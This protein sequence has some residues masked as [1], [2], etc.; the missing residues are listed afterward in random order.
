MNLKFL[1]THLIEFLLLFSQAMSL[2]SSKMHFFYCKKLQ[3]FN[4][5]GL[6]RTSDTFFIGENVSKNFFEKKVQ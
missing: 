2:K 3:I 4:Q 5:D 1:M 6:E